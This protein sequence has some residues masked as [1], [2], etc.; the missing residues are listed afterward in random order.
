[1]K[2]SF[3]AANDNMER[4]P[5]GELWMPVCRSY[6]C[7]SEWKE[8]E[9]AGLCPHSLIDDGEFSYRCL[10]AYEGILNGRYRTVT[11]AAKDNDVSV[12][13]FCKYRRAKGLKI[14]GEQI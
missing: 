11:E 14:K 8:C 5:D 6:W 2:Y 9:Y 1:M 13:G 10:A 7:Y 12:S 4:Q 3:I